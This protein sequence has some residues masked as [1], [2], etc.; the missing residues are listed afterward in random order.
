MKKRSGQNWALEDLSGI[1]FVGGSIGGEN[2]EAE[3][4][5]ETTS[6]VQ[7]KVGMNWEQ[8]GCGPLEWWG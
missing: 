3:R 2:L 5:M 4:C 7:G 6:A 8:V 1:L